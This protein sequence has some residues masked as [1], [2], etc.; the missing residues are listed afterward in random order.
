MHK[1]SQDRFSNELD[2]QK[3]KVD[4]IFFKNHVISYGTH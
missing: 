1:D 2:F 3:E 4:N